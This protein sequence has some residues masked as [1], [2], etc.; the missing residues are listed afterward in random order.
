MTIPRALAFLL[1]LG[2][3]V[4]PL[5]AQSLAIGGAIQ[6]NIQRF[7]GDASLNRLDGASPG[8]VIFGGARIGRLVVHAESSRDRTIRSVDTATLTVN[9]RPV[10]IR[11]ELSHDMREV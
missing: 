6:Q 4:A 7:E 2:I 9:A 10:T 1:A 3:S 8:W 5:R 11:S